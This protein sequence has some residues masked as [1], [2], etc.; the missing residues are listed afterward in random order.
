MS[1]LIAIGT[2]IAIPRAINAMLRIHKVISSDLDG[3]PH[4]E[5]IKRPNTITCKNEQHSPEKNSGLLNH[6]IS[7]RASRTF[8]DSDGLNSLSLKSLPL[9]S[10]CKPGRSLIKIFKPLAS[11][12]IDCSSV[13]I[14]LAFFSHSRRIVSPLLFSSSMNL[15]MFFLLKSD[16]KNLPF[17]FTP[18]Q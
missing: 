2:H 6:P 17:I 18:F 3:S 5:E 12:G 9:L 16:T 8:F 13:L 11:S 7:N 15:I 4:C 14:A 1:P 10:T